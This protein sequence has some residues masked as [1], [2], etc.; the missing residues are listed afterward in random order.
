MI[1]IWKQSKAKQS[2][3]INKKQFQQTYHQEKKSAR[4]NHKWPNTD[5]FH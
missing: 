5:P 3:G 1:E 4:P 2:K